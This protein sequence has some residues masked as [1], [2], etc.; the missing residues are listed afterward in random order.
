MC[1]S[2]TSQRSRTCYGSCPS[3]CSSSTSSLASAAID[4]DGIVIGL[5]LGLA[6]R[7]SRL[8]AGQSWRTHSNGLFVHANI[9]R[10]PSPFHPF[11]VKHVD[12]FASMLRRIV[13]NR[14]VALGLASGGIFLELA[15]DNDTSSGEVV[16]DVLSAGIEV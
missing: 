16:P 4:N 15:L 1:L 7:S 5:V 9:E 3:A 14:R 12:S 10:H 6:V 8:A 2:Y 11:A 13:L